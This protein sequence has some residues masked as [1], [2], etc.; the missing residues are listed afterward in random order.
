MSLLSWLF[1]SK[2][3]PAAAPVDHHDYRIYVEPQSEQG[4]YRVAARIEKDIGGVT[5]THQMIRADKCQSIEE[6]E[7]TSLLKA[8]MLID[9]QG[10][11]IFG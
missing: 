6:A 5:K 4:G 9:Q 1:G 7:E 11:S 2:A 10:E 3:K 8:K